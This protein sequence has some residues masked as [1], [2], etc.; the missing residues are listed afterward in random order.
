M[1]SFK[2][3]VPG[4]S[5]LLCISRPQRCEMREGLALLQQNFLFKKNTNLTHPPPLFWI[6]SLQSYGMKL[7]K[8][9]IPMMGLEATAF[10]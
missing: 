4:L 6:F 10:W 9:R 8:C 3:E 2:Q 1:L 7:A 5:V